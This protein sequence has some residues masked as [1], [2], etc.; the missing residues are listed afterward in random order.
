MYYPR[1]NWFEKFK[2]YANEENIIFSRTAL[3]KLIRKFN[4]TGDPNFRRQ[5][6]RH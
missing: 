5:M 1:K 2:A 4:K 6:N 3:K